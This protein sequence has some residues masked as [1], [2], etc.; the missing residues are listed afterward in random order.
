VSIPV[1]FEIH[2][3]DIWSLI[4]DITELCALVL[5]A[6]VAVRF[7]EFMKAYLQRYLINRVYLRVFNVST[8]NATSNAWPDILGRGCFCHG[9][10]SDLHGGSRQENS[11]SA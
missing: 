10:P 4:C 6:T 8:S 11:G 5:A 2:N 3:F 7:K 9:I 1:Q